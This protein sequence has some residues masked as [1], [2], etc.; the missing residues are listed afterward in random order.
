MKKQSEYG[1]KYLITAPLVVLGLIFKLM[2]WPGYS[3][4]IIAGVAIGQIDILWIIKNWL[5]L[6]IDNLFWVC[7]IVISSDRIPY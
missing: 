1:N 6:S 5:L 4:V 7:V 3:T 2:Y